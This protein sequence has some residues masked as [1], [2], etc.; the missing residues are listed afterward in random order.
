MRNVWQAALCALA[1]LVLASPAA[2]DDKVTGQT[3]VRHDGGTDAGIAHCNNTASNPAPV[4]PAAGDA[5]PNDGGSR[6]QGNEP[7]SVVDPTNPDHIYAGWNDYCLSDLAAGWQGFAFS[8]NGGDT[9]TDSIVPGY[10]QDTSTEG[11][12]SPL[13]GKHT[14]AGDPIAAFDNDGNLYVGGI[15]FNRVGAI[16]GD[17]Y[18]ATYGTNDPAGPYPVD[19]L[20]TVV[21][22]KGTPSRNF[23]GIFQDKPMLEVDRTGGSHDGNVYV[24]WSRFTGFGQNKV[25]FSRST[26]GGATFSRPISISRENDIRSVQGCDIAVEADGDVY[27]TFRTFNAGSPKVSDA[28]GFA[29]SSDGGATFGDASVIR[30]I[31]PYAP[32]DGTRDCGDGPTL[33]P[34]DFVF[35]RVPLEPRATSDQSG[36]LPGVYVVYNEV[37]SSVPSTTSYASAEPGRVGQSLTYVLQLM[38]NG[39]TVNDFGAVDAAATGHQFFP[40]IDA[41]AGKLAVVWQDNRTDDDY[42]VQ[43]PIGNEYTTFGGEQRAISS[44]RMEIVNTYAASLVSVVGGFTPST[45]VSTVGHQ[46]AYE[47]FSSRQLPFHGDYNWISIATRANGTAFAYMSWTDNR[48]VDEGNDPREL[49]EDGFDDNFDVEQCR[50]DL[51]ATATVGIL[52]SQI[53]LARRDAPFSGDNCGNAGGLDQDIYG[54]TTELG[55]IAAATTSAATARAGSEQRGHQGH[56]K[57]GKR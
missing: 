30:T 49:A 22:G 45:K 11:Q 42:S 27:V 48:N 10:P 37:R 50:V 24:C 7:Y 4:D 20:R 55:S 40:D 2:A 38:N 31:T 35:H 29:R 36:G 46:S 17:V 54:A 34:A 32:R 14:D 23:Q 12:A 15:A 1:L 41:F 44:G 52:S 6:R 43:F 21:V 56:G 9:W 47:M 57:K 28:L 5:D 51:G 39:A 33:C 53:P 25:Y 13:F 3:Y 26:D 19:Y 8:T 18:V 16:N